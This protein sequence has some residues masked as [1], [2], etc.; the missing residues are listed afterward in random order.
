MVDRQSAWSSG[1]PKNS[2]FSTCMVGTGFFM[3][4]TL[5]AVPSKLI[6]APKVA[7]ASTKRLLNL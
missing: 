2:S 3:I 7:N 4:V 1:C 5:I 6:L